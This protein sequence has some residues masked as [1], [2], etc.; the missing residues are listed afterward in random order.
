VRRLGRSQLQQSL[1][2]LI[3]GFI[4]G[5]N[6][7]EAYPLPPAFSDRVNYLDEF[8]FRYAHQVFPSSVRN[9]ERQGY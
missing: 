9:L 7:D 4:A 2:S 3:K 5:V 1:N 8:S 6:N